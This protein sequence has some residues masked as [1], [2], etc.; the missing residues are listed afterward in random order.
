MTTTTIPDIPSFVDL[1][2]NDLWSA[3]DIDNRARA[4]VCSVVPT[5]RQDELRTILLGHLARMRAATPAEMAEIG[6]VK[7]TTEAAAA[8]AAQARKDMA[9]LTQMLA[10]EAALQRLQANPVPDDE[11]DVQARADAQAVIDVVTPEV[12]ALYG[13]RH[14]VTAMGDSE[15]VNIQGA[16]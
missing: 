2:A 11:V 7:A 12:L 6:M 5:E 14:P 15:S 8:A 10:Y 3:A 13:L 9:L 16:A 1:F 4:I